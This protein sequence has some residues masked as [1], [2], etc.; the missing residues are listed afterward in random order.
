MVNTALEPSERKELGAY[1]ERVNSRL[2]GQHAR[3]WIEAIWAV[4]DDALY[5]EA[6]G[7]LEDYVWTPPEPTSLVLEGYSPHLKLHWAW[8][9]APG[10]LTPSANLWGR[11]AFMFNGRM[12]TVSVLGNETDQI[13]V[14]EPY[15]SALYFPYKPKRIFGVAA[16]QEPL[17]P[18]M[19]VRTPNQNCTRAVGEFW[20]SSF[21]PDCASPDK[22][23]EC[24]NLLHEG[25]FRVW[26]QDCYALERLYEE[27]G[28]DWNWLDGPPYPEGHPAHEDHWPD[29]HPDG[30]PNCFPVWL[31]KATGM[32]GEPD[33]S[34]KTNKF[35]EQIHNL[36]TA[37]HRWV[38][39]ERPQGSGNV[40]CFSWKPGTKGGPGFPR[41]DRQDRPARWN[42]FWGIT[43]RAARQMLHI[44]ELWS[45]T[46]PPRRRHTH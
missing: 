3:V 22:P 11:H 12:Y 33:I 38:T 40:I 6:L 25:D 43:T 2:A 31:R 27:K 46:C 35:M 21:L 20:V 8:C 26:P 17:D 10:A 5:Q 41:Q 42:G 30:M 19:G 13:K 4:G 14:V 23:P 15:F 28:W 44:L 32:A 18:Q 39:R 16:V 1:Q 45:E 29:K 9:Q 36:C 34:S 37:A 24:M 7:S